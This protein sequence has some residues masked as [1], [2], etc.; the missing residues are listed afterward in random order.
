MKP[1]SSIFKLHLL[2]I[3]LAISFAQCQPTS[4][5]ISEDDLKYHLGILSSDNMKGRMTATQGMDRAIQYITNQYKTAGLYPLADSYLLPFTFQDGVEQGPENHLSLGNEKAKVHPIPFGIPATISAKLVD[6][7]YCLPSYKGQDELADIEKQNKSIRGKIVI[8]KRYGPDQKDGDA[9]YQRLISFQSKYQNAIRFQPKAILFLQGDGDIIYT[10]Q[11]HRRFSTSET[12]A[13]FLPSDGASGG[14]AA[15]FIQKSLKANAVVQLQV[16]FGPVRRTGQNIA[17]ALRP[18]SK[19]QRIIYLGAHYDHLG[20]GLAGSS[21]GPMGQ[22]YNGADDNASGTVAILEIVASMK[23]KLDARPDFL[24]SDVN[25]IFVNFDA[26]ERGLFGSANFVESEFFQ[27]NQTIAMINLDMVGRL[28]KERGLFAQ[29]AETAQPSLQPIIE[30]SYADSFSK[31][32]AKEDQPDIRWVKGGLGPSDHASFYKKQVPVI[33]FFTGS[34]GQYH[35]PDDDYHLIQFQGLYAISE[36]TES[37]IRRLAFS[38]PLAFQKVAEEPRRTDFDFK[39]RLGVVPGSYETAGNEQGQ[40]GGLLVG[41]IVDG[42]PV[43]KT[44][45][46][47]GDRVIEIGSHKIKDIY[48]LMEFLNDART[49]TDYN[50]KWIRNDQLMQSKTRLM[51][52]D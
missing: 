5:D 1:T 17:A 44:G 46:Q 51:S 7:G 33:F 27:Q 29:G 14:N 30:A 4:T 47:D 23:Q 28:R 24:P 25:V 22:I 37:L 2:F 13:A 38:P 19:D 21:M 45:I 49:D 11:F 42:A 8:C 12:I 40:P 26:E 34:H 6:G 32:F 43:A 52:T 9:Q 39:V 20:Y 31:I 16:S 36:M 18:Y 15:D 35:K 10:D 50:I 3:I 41:G 48:D